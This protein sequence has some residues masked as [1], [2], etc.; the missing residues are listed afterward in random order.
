M[1]GLAVNI[2]ALV[3]VHGVIAGQVDGAV[4]QQVFEEPSGQE[5]SQPP[6]RPA[7]LREEAAV[8]GGI[9]GNKRSQ[10]TQEIGNAV[11]ADGQDGGAEQECEAQ[12]RGFAEGV[13]EG[14]AHQACWSG[15]SIV[16]VL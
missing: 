5:F 13:C 3:F 9:A 11:S 7:S 16:E 8:A 12:G 10:G 2:L 1:A 4:G 6:T 14:I 15:Q